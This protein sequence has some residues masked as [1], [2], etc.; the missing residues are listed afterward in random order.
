MEMKKVQTEAP[1]AALE[2][3][4]SLRSDEEGMSAVTAKLILEKK[5]RQKIMQDY[6]LV[7]VENKGHYH[8][9][10]PQSIARRDYFRGR[11]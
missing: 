5:L 1:D 10:S 3:V 4:S 9:G 11:G 2:D 7:A 6:D 8:A